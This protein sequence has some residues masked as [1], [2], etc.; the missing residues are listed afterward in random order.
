MLCEAY[1]AIIKT[2]MPPKKPLGRPVLSQASKPGVKPY[3]VKYT[4][5]QNQIKVSKFASAPNMTDQRESE[6]LAFVERMIQEEWEDEVLPLLLPNS[7]TPVPYD[8]GALLETMLD[9]QQETYIPGVQC[10]MVCCS[11]RQAQGIDYS[12]LGTK[13]DAEQL[14]YRLE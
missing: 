1:G 4:G 9:D 14:G 12:S 10:G 6:W 7:S 2:I 13:R 11:M 3:S 8:E 5:S